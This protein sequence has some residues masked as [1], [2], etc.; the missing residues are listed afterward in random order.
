MPFL[1]DCP[2]FVTCLSMDPE[3][4]KFDLC[5][6]NTKKDNRIDITLR[7]LKPPIT[8]AL[9]TVQ[10][11]FGNS[12]KMAMIN[13]TWDFCQFMKNRQRASVFGR[14]F[15]YVATY[16]NLNHTCPYNHDIYIRNF[17]LMGK[18]TLIAGPSGVYKISLNASINRMDRLYVSLVMAVTN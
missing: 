3:F 8:K 6:L 18:N 17:T 4:S 14:I 11:L 1:D 5:Q 10:F 7:L 12:F 13:N 2:S 9:A 15:D 16:S